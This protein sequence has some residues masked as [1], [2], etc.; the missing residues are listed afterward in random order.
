MKFKSLV[1]DTHSEDHW[2]TLTL[3]FKKYLDV[4]Y[5]RIQ[6]QTHRG[7]LRLNRDKITKV[8]KFKSA[9]LG[10]DTENHGN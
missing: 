10:S 5:K 4:E 3:V 1:L 6:T 7:I 9:V 8:M 2:K